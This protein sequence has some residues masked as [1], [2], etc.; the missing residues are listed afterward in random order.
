[1]LGMAKKAP[2]PVAAPTSAQ[3]QIRGYVDSVFEYATKAAEN[4]RDQLIMNAL[5][6]LEVGMSATQAD[7]LAKQ[8]GHHIAVQQSIANAGTALTGPLKEMRNRME[9]D[10]LESPEALAAKFAP[11]VEALSATAS[12]PKPVKLKPQPDDDGDVVTLTKEVE[13]AISPKAKK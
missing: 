7:M 6:S 11:Q 5:K 12:K 8:H 9:R 3:D 4:Y 13:K 1:M 10:K 2:E